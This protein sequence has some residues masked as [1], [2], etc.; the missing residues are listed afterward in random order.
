MSV[1]YIIYLFILLEVNF[2]FMIMKE[3]MHTTNP[4]ADPERGKLGI[5]RASVEI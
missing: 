4:L 3:K 5:F 2:S 1:L